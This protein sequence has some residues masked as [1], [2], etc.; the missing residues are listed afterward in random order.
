M[1][2]K[3]PILQPRF[4]V[5][6][7]G[8]NDTSWNLVRILRDQTEGAIFIAANNIEPPNKVGFINSLSLLKLI[9]K[10]RSQL[11]QSARKYVFGYPTLPSIKNTS[12]VCDYV[13]SMNSPEFV[14][15]LEN[16]KPD[17][18]LISTT[19][20]ISDVVLNMARTSLNI[21]TGFLP[22][23]RGIATL[24]WTILQRNFEYIGVTIRSVPT[25]LDK[26][27]VWSFTPTP[28][29][30][31]ETLSQLK[32]RAIRYGQY[33]LV[34]AALIAASGTTVE[35]KE[36]NNGAHAYLEAHQPDDFKLQV[37]QA[38][39][40]KN[41][42]RYAARTKPGG[43]RMSRPVKNYFVKK[44]KRKELSN[45]WYVVNYHDICRDSEF[46][47]SSLKIPSIYT[48][49]SRFEEHLEFWKNQFQPV[50]INEGLKLL[51]KNEAKNSRYLTITF[52]DGLKTPACH[53]PALNSAGFRPCL[54][55]SGNP[56][57]N[58][59]PLINHTQ[60]L[61]ERIAPARAESVQELSESI[62]SIINGE[63][64]TSDLV[65]I[66]M[67]HYLRSE[68]FTNG[69]LDGDFDIGAHSM[70]HSRPTQMIDLDQA[71]EVSES[72][73]VVTAA[74]GREVEL[75]AHPFG[76][77]NDRS[78]ATE[79]ASQVQASHHFACAGGINMTAGVTGALSRIAIH[80]E[81]VDQLRD[82]MLMQWTT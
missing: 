30:L 16:F 15:L 49:L 73:K 62:R 34:D 40:S 11:T 13:G 74:T 60:L 6:T 54:F 51:D 53:L 3:K 41:L 68:D 81:S 27:V 10:F 14:K 26:G 61:A 21:H 57:S 77:I 36:P 67:S 23:Y 4:A 39:Q 76:K 19:N 72:L 43:R 9:R 44:L 79:W 56:L 69:N 37:S 48:E 18:L 2:I 1:S 7:S 52:D 33:A 71:D 47:N 20:K 65:K 63:T 8:R 50:S 32:T 82:L 35:L 46:E 64:T 75:Y 38:S 80:N 5:L 12:V 31:Y 66:V 55:L 29:Y 78:F 58:E 70:S 28:P 45:G 22:Y 59:R 24:D 17:V 42:N 25:Q